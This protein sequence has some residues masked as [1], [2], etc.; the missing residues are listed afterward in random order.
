MSKGAHCIDGGYAM[1][2]ERCSA[3]PTLTFTLSP[4]ATTGHLDPLGSWENETLGR[5]LQ[6]PVHWDIGNKDHMIGS[7]PRVVS[8]GQRR[9]GSYPNGL[10]WSILLSVPPSWGLDLVKNPSIHVAG[11]LLSLDH[12]VNKV[13]ILQSSITPSHLELCHI[14]ENQVHCIWASRNLIQFN[15]RY[16]GETSLV[17][18]QQIR[19]PHPSRLEEGCSQLGTSGPGK[20]V[21]PVEPTR[22]PGI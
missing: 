20:H 6:G 10:P 8:R 9:K 5:I 21:R 3:G 16:V 15:E 17:R 2:T 13:K 7:I 22:D 19:H 14:F 12:M 11:W 4:G 1:D 18:I